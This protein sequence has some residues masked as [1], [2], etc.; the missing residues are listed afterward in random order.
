MRT[1]AGALLAEFEAAA[2]AAEEAE[3]ALRKR[4][5]VQVSRLE[6][7]RAFAYRRLNLMRTLIRA[8]GPAESEAAAVAG[9]LAAVRSQLGWESDTDTRTETLKRLAAVVRATFANLAPAAEVETLAADVPQTL[10]DFE[11]WYATT[12]GRPFWALFEQ[13]IPEMPLVER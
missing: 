3:A 5:Q 13:E 12:Y 11:A 6:S 1:A 7:E 4:M 2:T 9:G 8:I 10:G